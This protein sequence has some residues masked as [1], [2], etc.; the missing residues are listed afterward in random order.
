MQTVK[1]TREFTLEVEMEC[2]AP[3]TL[4]RYAGPPEKCYPAEDPE[5]DIV[6]VRLLDDKGD[7]IADL[8][9]NALDAD[10]YRNLVE[11]VMKGEDI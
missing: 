2:T 10:D 7:A 11:S 5:F 1:Y 6:G 9:V 4:G 3:G 8:P